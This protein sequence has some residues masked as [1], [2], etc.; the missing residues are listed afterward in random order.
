MGPRFTLNPIR[1]GDTRVTGTGPARLPIRIID[2]SLVGEQIGSGA[3]DE[4]GKFDI[5]VSPPIETQ[6]SIGIQIGD[7]QGTPFKY[8]DFIWGEGYKDLPMVGIIFTTTL[9]TK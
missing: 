8:E 2:V 9:S 3:I 5:S 1:A 4:N 6:H 7:L